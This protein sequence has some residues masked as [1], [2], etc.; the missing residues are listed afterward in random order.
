M[1]VRVQHFLFPAGE[2][3]GGDGRWKES[4]TRILK[5]GKKSGVI[6]ATSPMPQ[7]RRINLPQIGANCALAV[8]TAPGTENTTLI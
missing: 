7:D 6:C 4:V 1:V 5:G 2:D 8:P 3:I